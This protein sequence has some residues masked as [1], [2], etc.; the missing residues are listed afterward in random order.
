MRPEVSFTVD[1]GEAGVTVE[2]SDERVDAQPLDP[3]LL[4]GL[5]GAVQTTL[6]GEGVQ[7]GSVDVIA[8]DVPTITE[9]N[10]HHMGHA[11]PTDVLSFP[12]DDPSEGDSFGFRP[13]VGDIVVC[14]EVAR[15]Q[16]PGHAGTVEAE[17]HLLVI[18]SA[19]HLLGHDHNTESERHA[20]QAKEKAH[21]ERFGFGHPGDH[22]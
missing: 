16:A 4:A 19:L 9:L 11:G 12:L 6:E 8:V 22:V 10:Q 2:F 7:S 15:Q 13:H 5:V 3:N 1:L 18:H 20:M 14:P 21:L 17:L